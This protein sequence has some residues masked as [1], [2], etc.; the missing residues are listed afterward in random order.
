MTQSKGFH[1][2]M[3][4]HISLKYFWKIH[5]KHYMT[6]LR[7]LRHKICFLKRGKVVKRQR[8]NTCHQIVSETVWIVN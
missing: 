3:I 6:L 4:R 7:P 5:P 2:D 1:K 8:K